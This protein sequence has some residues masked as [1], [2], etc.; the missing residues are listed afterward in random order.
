TVHLMKRLLLV[1]LFCASGCGDSSKAMGTGDGGDG[2]MTVLGGITFPWGLF[3]GSVPDVATAAAPGRTWYCDPVK[4]SDSNDGSSFA[5]AKKKIGA[6]L[7]SGSVKAGDTVLL[8][9]G[10]YREYPSFEMVAGTAA[11]P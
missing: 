9:G 5:L 6:M 1:A 4:G 10:I 3:D 8:G 11:A 7:T 2:R